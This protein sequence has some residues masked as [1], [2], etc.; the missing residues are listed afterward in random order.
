MLNIIS[1]SA[2]NIVGEKDMQ[3]A[4]CTAN[5]E[6][7]HLKSFNTKE[8]ISRSVKSD[9]MDSLLP[10]AFDVNPFLV[11][12]TNLAIPRSSTPVGFAGPAARGKDSVVLRID[13]VPWVCFNWADPLSMLTPIVGHYSPHD[14]QLVEATYRPCSRLAR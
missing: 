6:D 11:P 10:S 12:P 9:V 2:L 8:A 4:V 3:C 14:R 1:F 13:N 7:F 5:V